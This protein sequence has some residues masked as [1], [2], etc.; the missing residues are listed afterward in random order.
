MSPIKRTEHIAPLSRDHH[1]GLLFSWKINQGIKR[2]TD[3]KRIKSYIAYF[4]ENHLRTHFKEEEEILFLKDEPGC[5]Q[6][7]KEHAEI[8]RLIKSITENENP[9]TANMQALANMISQHIR[10]EERE[11][12]LFLEQKLSLE[13]L[14][15]IGNRLKELHIDA[16]MDNYGDEFWAEKP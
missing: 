10:F 5:M 15:E 4:W 12:F 7:E 14:T 1:F 16:P 6:A 11:L 3:A 13:Q 2:G 8:G 9:D